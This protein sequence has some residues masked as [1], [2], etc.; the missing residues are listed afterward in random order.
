MKFLT[1]VP[2]IGNLPLIQESCGAVGVTHK[3]PG[4]REFLRFIFAS[5]CLFYG[6]GAKIFR[7]TKGLSVN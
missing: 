2:S 6:V 5:R 3:S 4:P 7:M 1:R